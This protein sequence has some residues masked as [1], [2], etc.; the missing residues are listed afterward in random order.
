MK[1]IINKTVFSIL[2]ACL[3]TSK[4]IHAQLADAQ[5]PLI[6]YPQSLVPATGTF[7]ITAATPIVF[8][9]NHQFANEITQLNKLF[10]NAFGVPLKRIA[11]KH[12][13]DAIWVKY[14]PSI[15]GS[16]GYSLTIT[17]KQVTIS[18][19]ESAGMYRA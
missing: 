1:Y 9:G 13:V 15:T 17:D 4:I 19:K 10:T 8:S 18:A 12:P 2:C 5:Y 3:L 11:K 7:K 6:P 16:E 14:D